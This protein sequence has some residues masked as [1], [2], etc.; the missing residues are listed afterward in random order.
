MAGTP[1][2]PGAGPRGVLAPAVA[3][4]V[5]GAMEFVASGASLAVGLLQVSDRAS[6]ST[7]GAADLGDLGTVI[8][9]VI[10]IIGVVAAPFV[11]LAGVQLLRGRTRG[12]VYVGAAAAMVP[13]SFCCLLGIPV[14]V[15]TMVIM[16]RPAVR[17]HFAASP[18]TS[19]DC[20]TPGP[21]VGSGT[22]R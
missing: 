22:V 13:G 3:L 18:G 17:A 8:G 20:P 12:V 6:R 19:P 2:G 5:V 1:S 10:P 11:V 16:P 21:G 7:F 15:W 14:A 4:I 9:P